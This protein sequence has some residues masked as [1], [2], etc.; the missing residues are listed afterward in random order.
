[1]IKNK[2]QFVKNKLNKREKALA[3]Q[4][5]AGRKSRLDKKPLPIKAL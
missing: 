3:Q 5:R 2:W 1:M 4:I